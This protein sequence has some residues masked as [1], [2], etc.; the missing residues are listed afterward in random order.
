MIDLSTSDIT[1]HLTHNKPIHNF[2]V[3]QSFNKHTIHQMTCLYQL[4]YMSISIKFTAHQKNNV[5]C[6]RYPTCNVLIF[7]KD[8]FQAYGLMWMNHHVIS[9]TFKNVF[10]ITLID[11][12]RSA[13]YTQ[14]IQHADPRVIP[15]IFNNLSV[16]GTSSVAINSMPSLWSCRQ[17]L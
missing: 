16:N 4:P 12:C 7:Q 3:I 5:I 11:V 8:V 10:V 9:R 17:R 1:W 15:R 13:C 6:V 2:V 14:S